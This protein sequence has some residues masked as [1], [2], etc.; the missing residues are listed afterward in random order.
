MYFAKD[1]SGGRSLG[2]RTQRHQAGRGFGRKGYKELASYIV[3]V[4]SEALY[5]SC[6]G[7]LLSYLG[8]VLGKIGIIMNPPL[9][10]LR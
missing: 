8:V 1:F 5:F 4:K 6:M 10:P 7:W 2:R 9:N 3:R